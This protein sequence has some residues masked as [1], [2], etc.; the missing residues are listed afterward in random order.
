[1]SCP[2]RGATARGVMPIAASAD[3]DQAG[4]GGLAFR[5]PAGSVAGVKTGVEDD[6]EAAVITTV[7]AVVEGAVK[8]GIA[9]V[10]DG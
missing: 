4:G 6:R 3:G 2:E 10:G 9:E 8:G 1:M 7:K 5:P